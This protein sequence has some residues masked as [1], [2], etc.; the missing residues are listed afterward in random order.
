MDVLRS[1]GCAGGAAVATVTIVHPVDTV[2]TRLQVSGSAGAR[3]YRSLGVLGTV[4]TVAAEEGITAFW[5]GIPAAWMR[6]ASYTSIRLGLYKPIVTAMNAKSGLEKFGA[7]CLAGGIGSIIGN[8]FDVLKVNMM[9]SEGASVGVGTVARNIYSTQGIAGF[10]RGMDANVARA[11]VNN[12]TKMAVYDEC[13][14]AIK[15]TGL[16]AKDGQ[17]IV[18]ASATIAGFFMTLTV[19]PFDFVRTRLMNQPV[20]GPKL[21]NSF[22][23]CFLKVIKGPQ[24]VM[25]L[26]SGFIPMWTRVAPTATLQL[27]AFE[28]LMKISGGKSI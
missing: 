9:A 12:G 14:Q 27:M 6:E 20:G 13:K 5:K 3:D 22:A 25:V 11:M 21:Y 28:Q 16:F 24:G 1:L 17:A 8:P 23:D 19:A 15:K 2:K 7:G 26:W 4:R 18:M 10:Y